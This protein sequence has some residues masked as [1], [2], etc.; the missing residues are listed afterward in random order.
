[1]KFNQKARLVVTAVAVLAV[2]GGVFAAKANKA[3]RGALVWTT[4]ALNAP[5]IN[6]ANN[7]TTAASGGVLTFGSTVFNDPAVQIRTVVLQ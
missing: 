5:A 6:P 7:R 2:V 4:N 3:K 1:M